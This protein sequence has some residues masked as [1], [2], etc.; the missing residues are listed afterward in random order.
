SKNMILGEAFRYITELKQQNDEMLLSG[1]DKVQAEEIKRLRHQLED[2]RKESAHYIELLKANGINFLD[3][4]TVHWKGKQRCA[5]A[6]VVSQ[7]A[8]LH[9]PSAVPQT[10]LLTQTPQTAVAAQPAIL[11]KAVPPTH[12]HSYPA[13][14]PKPQLHHAIPPQP[15]PQPAMPSQS[16]SHPAMMPQSQSAIVPPIQHTV[17]PQPQAATLPVLQ[18]MQVLQMNSDGAPVIGT[19]PAQNNP[20]VVI[21][22]QA[23]PCPASQVIREDV[24][25]HTPCQ[26]IVI[27]QT[28]TMAPAPQNH[29][30]SIVPTTAPTTL[31]THA[32]TS[33]SPC[34]TAVQA[35]VTKQLVH[36]LPRP[37]TQVQ[38]P[39]QTQVQTPMQTQVQ[40]QAP[41]TITVNGQV[42]VLQSV[43]SA[44]NGSS[45]DTVLL[46]CHHMNKISQVQCTFNRDM[47]SM[48]PHSL[49]RMWEATFTSNISNNRS[50][51]DTSTNFIITLHNQKRR[52]MVFSRGLYYK[53]SMCIKR[54]WCVGVRQEPL[55][56]CRNN[57]T[58]KRVVSSRNSSI[59]SINNSSSSPSSIS[60]K[61]SNTNSSPS[62]TNSISNNH[63]STNSNK[64]SSFHSSNSHTSSNSS[65]K[66]SSRAPIHDISIFSSRFSSSNIS[67]V[68]KRRI[69]RANRLAPGLIRAAI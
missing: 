15:E 47:H 53:I 69:V 18:A 7:P 20:N 66:Y 6:T 56:V 61:L 42:Y 21:L 37:T 38:T 11:P 35:N 33:S 58:W 23:S 10:T 50:S 28:P 45:Q 43:K 5:K 8:V 25:S 4:P 27:I 36:I 44:E 1:G 46:S 59:S 24:T 48:A 52:S 60:S 12:S 31:P 63:S 64:N 30:T 14:Q 32:T 68:D 57:I 65:S 19:A 41:Q 26:H 51:R 39:M 54:G 49:A 17:V 2:L 16:Q 29:Q 3:D 34:T 62:S 40:T 55:L 13:I 67:A 9:Q 22:Q